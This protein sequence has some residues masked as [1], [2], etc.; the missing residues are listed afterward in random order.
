MTKKVFIGVLAV[1]I[2]TS[3]GLG[4]YAWKATRTV[5]TSSSFS[6]DVTPSPEKEE[7]LEWKDQAGFAFRYP[8]SL[9]SNIHEEDKEHYAH[10][11]LTHPDYP[12]S[13]IIW[14]KDT[15]A[16]DAAAWV[17][18]EKTLAGGTVLDTTFANQAAKKVLL[19]TPKNKIITAAVDEAI[20][21]YVEGTLEN[22][23]FWA[24]TYDTIT[25]TFVFTPLGSD[26]TG[27]I[28]TGSDEEVAVDEE[29]V[30]E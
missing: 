29:E 23:D 13:I 7:L 11:E 26:A 18:K 3:A 6:A 25:S 20:A 4:V 21:F 14:A 15:S 12:G 8:K 17:K 24:K 2:L 19:S 27:A 22:N 16:A 9:K 30:L 5:G 1:G 10:I 28:Q